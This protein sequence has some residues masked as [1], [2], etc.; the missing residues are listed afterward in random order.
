MPRAARW[1]LGPHRS[2]A[3]LTAPAALSLL[4]LQ[5]KQLRLERER[6]KAMREQELEMLQREKEAEHFKTWEEQE[7]NFHLQQAKLRCAG[8][9]PPLTQTR[10]R[11]GHWL[12][13]CTLSGGHCSPTPQGPTRHFLEPSLPDPF[14]GSEVPASCPPTLDWVQRRR[15]QVY[16]TPR[17]RVCWTPGLH[18]P[19]LSLPHSAHEG[20]P[21]HPVYRQGS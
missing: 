3:D 13:P 8:A 20:A 2:P 4:C 21:V 7:D 5:V 6:E 12:A 11:A 10:A 14:P 1:G 16:G 15:A 19:R 18:R 9:S 17:H